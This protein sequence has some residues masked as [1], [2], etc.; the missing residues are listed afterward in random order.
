MKTKVFSSSW[1]L[2]FFFFFEKM[3]TSYVTCYVL[4]SC[5]K[6]FKQPFTDV[7]QDRC[8]E[9]FRNICRKTPVLETLFNKFTR[10]KAGIFIK[11]T[12]QHGHFP[13][14]IARFFYGT[15][16]HCTSPKLYVMMDIRYLK[17]KFYYCKIRPRSRKNFTIDRSKFLVKICFFLN[18]EFN[19]PSKIFL[20]FNCLLLQRFVRS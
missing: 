7:F 10:F 17:V 14:N 13:M 19:S 3:S 5:R 12:L 20:L 6:T 8:S 15:F 4:Y 1:V 11:K 2:V 16:V 18:Q 9:K